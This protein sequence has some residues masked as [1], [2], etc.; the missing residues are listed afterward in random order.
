MK[1]FKET[2]SGER[3]SGGTRLWEVGQLLFGVLAGR[4]GMRG[5]AG[6]GGGVYICDRSTFQNL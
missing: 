6:R 4:D 3:L 2:D 1:G 5:G